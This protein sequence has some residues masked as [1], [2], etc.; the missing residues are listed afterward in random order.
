LSDTYAH[1]LVTSGCLMKK[2][3][4]F[5]KFKADFSSIRISLNERN[6]A[7]RISCSYQP[8]IKPIDDAL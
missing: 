2:F 6:G 8:K 3:H 5:F 4:I 7:E 1:S